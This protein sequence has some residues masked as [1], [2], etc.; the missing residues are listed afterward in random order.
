VS[1]SIFIAHPSAL[2]TDHEPHGDGL[3]AHG[4]I[5]ELAARGHTLHVAAQRVALRSGLPANVHLHVLGCDGGA[6]GRALARPS[7]MRRLRRLYL[8]LAERTP[9]DVI[10]QLNPVDAG[11]S[12][13]LAGAEP[14]VILG[15]YVPPWPFAHGLRPRIARVAGDALRWPQQRLA[16]TALVSTP[17]AAVRLWPLMTGRLH[18]HELSAGIDPRVWRPAEHEPASGDILF[19]GNLEPRKGLYVL[20]DAFAQ[21]A[22]SVP[23][24]RL[25]VAGG[26]SQYEEVRASVSRSPAL[27]RVD[28][29]GAVSHED[30]P[31]LMRACAVL[32]APAIGEPFGMAAL[33]AMACGKPVVASD[34]GGLRHLVRDG[35]G[36]RVP[37]GDSPALA[38]A[39]REILTSPR[40]QRDMGEF[41]RRRVEQHFTWARVIDRLEAVYAEAI[42]ARGR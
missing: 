4:F 42:A 40:L 39:L 5:A 26:G 31:H 27:A 8:A 2:L 25:L 20:L 33:E 30:V 18:V 32:C 21:L 15:P 9:F 1:L 13:A 24:A 36:R 19:V 16:T 28:L 11:I 37:V 12:L 35:G 10:H 41:N 34:A 23:E 6:A 7:Y 17:A 22:A 29:L 14:P 38:A 3:V